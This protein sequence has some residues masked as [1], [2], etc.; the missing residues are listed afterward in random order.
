MSCSFSTQVL[1][2]AEPISNVTF[3]VN[4]SV[5]L[6]NGYDVYIPG[7]WN[8]WALDATAKTTADAARK[9]F[10]LLVPSI[11]ANTYEFQIV[12]CPVGATE[13]KWDIKSAA[14]ANGNV[15]RA[16]NDNAGGTEVDILAGDTTTFTIA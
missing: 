10:S 13:L 2:P 1:P 8:G 14:N 3:V 16:V 6:P 15:S 9:K 11:Y 7:S 5:A 12:A 4:L